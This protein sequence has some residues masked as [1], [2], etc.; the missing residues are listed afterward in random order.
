MEKL[1]KQQYILL[2]TVRIKKVNGNEKSL[3][4]TGREKTTY[5]IRMDFPKI[6][7]RL[8]MIQGIFLLSLMLLMI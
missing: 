5:Q 2:K 6:L 4:Q 7:L 1:S 8:A 3:E